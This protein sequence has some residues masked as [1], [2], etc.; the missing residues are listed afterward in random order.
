MEQGADF[1]EDDEHLSGKC[2]FEEDFLAQGVVKH[3]GSR[4]AGNG[5][6]SARCKVSEGILAGETA[7]VSFL[8]VFSKIQCGCGDSR[9]AARLPAGVARSVLH[10]E[11]YQFGRF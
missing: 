3:E 10:E 7:V 1:G 5:E 9:A 11:F 8:Y 6:S 4:R 2:R